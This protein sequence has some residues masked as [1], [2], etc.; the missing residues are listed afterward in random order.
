MA[1]RAKTSQRLVG[2]GLYAYLALTLFFPVAI[3]LLWAFY[4][5]AVGWFPP[6]IV[7]RSLSLSAWREVL[8]VL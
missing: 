3:V 2:F 5:P 8:G 7:P 1:S 4:D 6:D